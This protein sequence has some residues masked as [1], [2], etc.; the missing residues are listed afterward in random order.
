MVMP[1]FLK[2]H[3]DVTN[4]IQYQTG[5]MAMNSYKM[6]DADAQATILDDE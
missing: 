6:N 3:R 5:F 2:I 4:E 1:P